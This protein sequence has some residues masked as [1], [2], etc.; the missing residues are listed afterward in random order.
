MAQ[1]HHDVIHLQHDGLVPIP[2]NAMEHLTPETLAR[3][4]QA[5]MAQYPFAHPIQ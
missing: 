4:A 1:M 3:F 2:Q 5:T